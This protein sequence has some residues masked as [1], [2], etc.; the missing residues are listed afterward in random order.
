MLG[1]RKLAGDGVF[2]IPNAQ[3]PVKGNHQCI[4]ASL[5]PRSAYL[6]G[7]RCGVWETVMESAGSGD[8]NSLKPSVTASL[9]CLSLPFLISP[10]CYQALA[11]CCCQ[12][13]ALRQVVVVRTTLSVQR[14]V[15]LLCGSLAHQ[16]EA[17][18]S[19]LASVSS[20]VSGWLPKVALRWNQGCGSALC[21]SFLPSSQG[22]SQSRSQALFCSHDALAMA[23]RPLLSSAVSSLCLVVFSS[24]T[25]P[26]RTV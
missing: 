10:A 22:R 24:L 4:H 23:L 15:Q 2:R 8:G 14:R 25:A 16:P 7:G 5:L 9:R 17:F 21:L 12:L 1:N 20:P 18:Q 11:I 19:Q 6:L 13:L 3:D 26:E